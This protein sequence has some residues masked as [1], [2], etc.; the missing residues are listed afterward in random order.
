MICLPPLGGQEI[1]CALEDRPG[2]PQNEVADEEDGRGWG[3]MIFCARAT[4][5]LRRPSLNARS[6]RS[7]SP[8]PWGITSKLGG[9]NYIDGG[10]SLRAVKDDLPTPSGGTGNRMRAIEDR[11]GPPQNEVADD[12]DGGMEPDD[13]LCSRN[14]RPQKD[15]EGVVRCPFLLAER[16]R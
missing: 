9:I 16:A 8:H 12:E 13:L 1:G 15:G 10:R 11:P 2:H 4:R 3:L 6:R 7:I 5:G 14:A